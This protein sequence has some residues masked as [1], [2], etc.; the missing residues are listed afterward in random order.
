M[1]QKAKNASTNDTL[2][3]QCP[4]YTPFASDDLQ[5]CSSGC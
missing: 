3:R 4:L 5:K 1:N 2:V